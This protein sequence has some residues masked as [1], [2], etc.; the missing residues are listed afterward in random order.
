MTAEI[1]QLRQDPDQSA[2]RA[3]GAEYAV[4]GALLL[5][6]S[7]ELVLEVAAICEAGDF[8]Y[9]RDKLIFGLLVGMAQE[10]RPICMVTLVDCIQAT[11][12]TEEYGGL[13][14]VS[15]LPD[16]APSSANVRE[17]AR[18]VREAALRRRARVLAGELRELLEGGALDTEADLPEVL[19]R[20]G[21]AIEVLV[22]Q[23][24]EL[25]APVGPDPLVRARLAISKQDKTP[26]PTLSNVST[27]F[28]E[29]PRWSSLRLNLLGDT[30]EW[31]GKVWEQGAL[32]RAEAARWLA[33]HYQLE[34]NGKLVEEA[35]LAAAQARAYHPVAEYL[36]GLTWDGERRIHRLLDEALGVEPTELLQL[37]VR[38]FLLG[39]VARA[40][41]PGS[42]VDT[43]LIL[44]GAQ[45]ARKSS[46]FREL[47][48]AGWFGDSPIPIGDK[49][50]AIQ[51]RA[52]WGYEA[53]EMED[54]SRK[55]AE[56]VKQFLSSPADLYR[57]PYERAA[58]SRPRHS[59]LCGSTNRAEFL[60]DDTGSRRFWP[61]TVPDAHVIRLDLVRAWRDQLW[62][63]AMAAWQAG[64]PWWFERDEEERLGRA[65]DVARYQE[66]DPWEPDVE[67]YLKNTWTP[68]STEEVMNGLK[69][70]MDERDQR[71]SRRLSRI[72]GQLGYVQKSI[73]QPSDRFIK[74]WSHARFSA[75]RP[76]EN[77]G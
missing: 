59:V 7:A 10:R 67:A 45:G 52:V 5:E 12:K 16:R 39:A 71:T 50:A 2:L 72:L 66:R 6:E 24:G 37:Y 76:D 41:R 47:F 46:F 21:R 58:S 35:L 30:L 33:R 68:F 65:V 34:A 70:R 20:A 53:A 31:Q 36:Q 17:H 13:G 26:R 44:V 74:R 69:L 29:D 22:A 51:L 28:M 3:T 40:M 57:A 4:L 75:N 61:I 42:K 23:V 55:T 64:E 15:S 73:R 11:G 77:P 48:G 14:Y 60:T 32:M 1:V 49:D 8:F 38:R 62:A 18:A 54:L 43:A 27:I 25:R 56:A 63:E 9:H 19:A